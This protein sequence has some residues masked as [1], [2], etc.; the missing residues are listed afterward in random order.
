M[1]TQDLLKKWCAEMQVVVHVNNND[2][3]RGGSR[4]KGKV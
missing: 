3:E 2:K 4:S 1:K